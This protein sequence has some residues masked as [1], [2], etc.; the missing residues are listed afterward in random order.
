MLVTNMLLSQ[1]AQELCCTHESTTE[2]GV[3]QI[4][5]STQVQN[6]QSALEE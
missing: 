1:L 6:W 3:V 2:Q 4:I 5:F